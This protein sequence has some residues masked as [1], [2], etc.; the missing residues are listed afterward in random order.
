M[1]MKVLA[2]SFFFLALQQPAPPA[3]LLPALKSEPG[4]RLLAPATDLREYTQDQLHKFGYWPP[5]LEL[6]LD[7]DKRMDVVAVVVKSTSSGREFGLAAVH[8]TAPN[9]IHWVV[10][11]DPEPINGVTRGHAPDTVVPLFCV[12]CDANTWLRW[13]GEEYETELHAVGE[14]IDIGTEAERD[15]PLHSAPNPGSKPAATVSHCATVVVRKVGGTADGRWY[16]VETADG[17]RGWIPERVVSADVC[18]G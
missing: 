11:L 5:W 7:R 15:L 3:L 12:E 10:P 2:L 18:V 8:A 4:L 13:S 1:L 14:K 17:E 16:F 9:E 6:D